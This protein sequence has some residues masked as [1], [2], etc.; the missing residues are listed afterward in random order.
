MKP[1]YQHGGITIWHGDSRD[2]IPKQIAPN[3]VKLLWSDPPYGNGNHDGDMNARLNEQRGKE[4]YP[5]AND[6]LE[7]M[8][9]TVGDVLSVAMYSLL[10][11]CALCV[12]CGGGGG[13]SQSFLWL[14][15]RM[16]ANGLELFHAVVWDKVNPGLGWRYRRQYEMIMV[17]H[18]TGSKMAWQ[19]EDKAFPNI[20]RIASTYTKARIHPNEKPVSLPARFIRYHTNRGDTVL[21]PFMGSGTTLRACKDEGRIGI[22]IELDEKHCETAAL[23]LSQEQLFI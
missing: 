1:Y 13:G 14:G 21:D 19:A 5:I 22:G 7:S 2:V 8:R 3:S 20:I 12:C 6:D 17:S 16:N 4:S 9:R 15:N 23:M 10:D 18:K 11:D